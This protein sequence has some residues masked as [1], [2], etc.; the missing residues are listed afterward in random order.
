MTIFKW[1][2]SQAVL[3]NS[4]VQGCFGLYAFA[5]Y[6][7]YIFLDIGKWLNQRIG[8][9]TGLGL[10]VAFHLITFPWW[11]LPGKITYW[12]E[13]II[14]NGTEVPNPEPV[15]CR[16]S[17]K[18]CE[19]TPPVNVYLYVITYVLLIGL[20]FPAINIT[21][22]TIY[23]TVIGPRQQNSLQFIQGT[24]QGL[25]VVSGS[26]ARLLGPIFISRLFTSYGP[27]AAW[28]MELAITGAMI[29]AW[30]IFYKRMVPLKRLETMSAGDIVR[31]KLGLVYRL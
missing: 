23:S 3:Y 8:C 30:I 4:I 25:L 21:L 15:G 31:C 28:G 20:A 5:I 12:Q 24:M 10:L 16:P 14:V 13:T 26:C 27:R 22:N 9:I 19:Y 17:F 29:I 1:K 2:A 11:G 7:S 18:W 6:V